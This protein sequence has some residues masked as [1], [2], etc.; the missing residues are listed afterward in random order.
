MNYI[1]YSI[2]DFFAQDDGSIEEEVDFSNFRKLVSSDSSKPGARALA[3]LGSGEAVG[4]K[5]LLRTEYNANT[6]PSAAQ[7]SDSDSSDSDS[8]SDSSDSDWNSDDT[9]PKT[10]LVKESD[11]DNDSDSDSNSDVE[12]CSAAIESLPVKATSATISAKKKAFLDL[13]GDGE[14]CMISVSS[15]CLTRS[16][17]AAEER[18]RPSLGGAVSEAKQAQ[19]GRRRVPASPF[20]VD[21][22]ARLRQTPAAKQTRGA[23]LGKRS[24]S[25]PLM[26]LRR[27]RKCAS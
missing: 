19:K 1:F 10:N 6:N 4:A 18:G 8:D 7:Q 26:P 5:S 3:L 20:A 17:V 12:N 23:A 2:I 21:E 25:T 24:A 27:R 13:F 22:S 9:Q 11:S 16:A 14:R 15:A